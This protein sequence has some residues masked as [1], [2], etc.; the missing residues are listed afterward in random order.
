MVDRFLLDTGF[1]VALAN[2]KDPEHARCSAFAVLAGGD[3]HTVEGVM[4]EAAWLLAPFA[5]GAQRA[6]EIAAGWNT[7]WAP[8]TQARLARSIELSEKYRDVPMDF[9]DASLVALAEETGISNILSLD[10]R[11]FGVYRIK[12]KKHFTVLPPP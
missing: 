8:A 5:G 11:G 9:V 3:V 12:G 7:S 2:R 10:A 1:L 6:L 4:V